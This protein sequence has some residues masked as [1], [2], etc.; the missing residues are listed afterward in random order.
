MPLQAASRAAP[1]APLLEVRALSV[2]YSV[3]AKALPVVRD[4]NLSLLPGES[5]GLV[6]ESGC[7]KSTV[8]LA[9]MQWLGRQGRITSGQLLFKGRDLCLLSGEELRRTRGAQVAMI[10]QEP[11]ASLN[12]TMR[13]GEQLTEVP[14]YNEGLSRPAARAR[15]VAMLN[16]VQLA[17]TL[18]IMEAYPHQLSGGQQQRIV[19]AMA[20]LSNPSLLLLDEPTTALDVTVEAGIVDLIGSLSA[21]YGMSMLY[22]S[23]NLALLRTI[24]QRITVMYAG[25]VVETAE[26][27]ALFADP[28]HPYTRQL[29]AAMPQPTVHKHA[30]PLRAIPGQPPAPDARPRGCAFG[31][32][33]GYFMAGRCDATDVPLQVESGGHETR[34]LRAGEIAWQISPPE[35]NDGPTRTPGATALKLHSLTKSYGAVSAN[36][37]VSFDVRAGETVALVGESGSGKSTVA[38]IL[39]GLTQATSGSAALGAVE[40]AQLPVGRRPAATIRALQMIFQNPFDTLNPSHTIGA[41]IARV[42]RKFKIERDKARIDARVQELLAQVQLPAEIASRHPQQLSGGQKQRVAIARAFAGHPQLVVADEPVS[43]LDVSVQATV[44]ALLMDIQRES[45]TTLLFISHDLALVRQLADRVIVMYQGKV[46]EQGTVEEVFAPPYHPYTE[47]LLAAI[48]IADPRVT[49]RR[50]RPSV[51]APSASSPPAGCRFSSRCAYRIRG[52]CEVQE[53][54]VREFAPGHRIACH[55]PARELSEMQPIFE[56]IRP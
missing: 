44:V 40:L 50:V 3:D 41:Q 31:P 13:I 56:V 38:R 17:D 23:H 24:C 6:G 51:E 26:T 7:G 30:Q 8:A 54:P 46:I 35:L 2:A 1:T 39:M 4:F 47:A 49:R 18:R 14:R 16:R 42:I 19:I 55:L 9:I 28:H 5:H 12:P 53:P 22:I 21:E 27:A 43:S 11:M 29:L 37:R 36:E 15:A 48:P 52:T 32:R 20:L 45:G 34:C 33:C 10:Y 25:Q